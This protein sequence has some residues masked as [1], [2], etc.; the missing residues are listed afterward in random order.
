MTLPLLIKKRACIFSQKAV[1]KPNVLRQPL[2]FATFYCFPYLVI[3]IASASSTHVPQKTSLYYTSNLSK[4]ND[5][6]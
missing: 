3:L 5:G 6:D 2:F 4:K 1:A